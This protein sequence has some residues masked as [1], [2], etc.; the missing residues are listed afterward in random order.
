MLILG[1]TF[2]PNYDNESTIL[3]SLLFYKLK[4]NFFLRFDFK[5]EKLQ[6]I[7]DAL[8]PIFSAKK[9]RKFGKIPQILFSKSL[10]L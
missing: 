7:A 8:N 1:E 10:W 2:R 5:K 4:I 9:N 6:I 3:V